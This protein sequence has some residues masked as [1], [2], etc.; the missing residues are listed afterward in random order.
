TTSTP[1][2]SETSLS[3]PRSG[4]RITY[5]RLLDEALG[6]FDEA[7]GASSGDGSNGAG[8]YLVVAAPVGIDDESDAVGEPEHVAGPKMVSGG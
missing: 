2:P 4:D 7:P 1:D 6:V 3:T 5:R 8:A